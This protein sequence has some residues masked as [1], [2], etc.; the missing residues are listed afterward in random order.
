MPAP[1]G[2]NGSIVDCD[3][4]AETI[5]AMH[6]AMADAS[7]PVERE[8]RC[9]PAERLVEHLAEIVGAGGLEGMSS[10]PSS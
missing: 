4:P 10:V 6:D 8:V 5:A 3:W 7:Q 9:E 1:L 2:K